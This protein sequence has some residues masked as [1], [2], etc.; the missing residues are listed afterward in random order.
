MRVRHW[1]NN[2]GWHGDLGHLLVQL[3]FVFL[4]CSCPIPDVPLPLY[5]EGYWACRLDALAGWTPPRSRWAALATWS[6]GRCSISIRPSDMPGAIFQM[7]YSSPLQMAWPCC[8]TPGVCIVIL[9]LEHAINSTWCFF[10]ITDNS[11]I[12]RVCSVI[13]LK[14]YGFCIASETCCDSKL[15]AFHDTW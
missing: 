7:V 1:Y 15:T 3:T 11:N 9:Q 10:S 12:S 8:R 14:Q 2:G 13:W 4:P 5:T 6:L